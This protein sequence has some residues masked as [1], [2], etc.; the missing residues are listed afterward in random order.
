MRCSMPGRDTILNDESGTTAVE[1]AVVLALLLSVIVTAVSTLGNSS[2][3]MWGKSKNE[4][5]AHGF[6]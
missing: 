4:L 1:Y 6:K 2:S 3:G 5:E